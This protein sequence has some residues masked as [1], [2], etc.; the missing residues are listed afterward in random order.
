M[1]NTSIFTLNYYNSEDNQ[2][3]H[4]SQICYYVLNKNYQLSQTTAQSFASVTYE[5][6]SSCGEVN[7]YYYPDKESC[8]KVGDVRK[9][10]WFEEGDRETHR[11]VMLMLCLDGQPNWRNLPE[12][13]AVLGWNYTHEIEYEMNKHQDCNYFP[14][15]DVNNLL[16]TGEVRVVTY[17][18][19]YIPAGKYNADD[20]YQIYATVE[21]KSQTFKLS[22]SQD[23]LWKETDWTERGSYGKVDIFQW[24]LLTGTKGE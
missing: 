5:W 20:Y 22:M 6:F 16:R 24:E 14:C 8:Y 7:E 23:G 10:T 21:Y 19:Q 13:I 3:E 18:K 4:D 9:S 15:F 12:D 2:P 11:E 17:E 1:T